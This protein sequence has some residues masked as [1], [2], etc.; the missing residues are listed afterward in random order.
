MFFIKESKSDLNAT[1]YGW[2]NEGWSDSFIANTNFIYDDTDEKASLE[3]L[4]DYIFTSIVSRKA[5]SE[6]LLMFEKYMLDVDGTLKHPY[7]MF[8]YQY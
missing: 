5:T 7:L 2:E 4:I 3:S 1:D 8:L 6:E